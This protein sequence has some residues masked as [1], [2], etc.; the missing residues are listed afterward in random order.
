[1][2]ILPAAFFSSLRTSPSR[3]SRDLIT[4]AFLPTQSA[5]QLVRAAGFFSH[6]WPAEETWLSINTSDAL[7][8]LRNRMS[9]RTSVT[10][11]GSIKAG[12]PPKKLSCFFVLHHWTRSESPTAPKQFAYF[13]SLFFLLKKGFRTG[14]SRA[15]RQMTMIT[16]VT[17]RDRIFMVAARRVSPSAMV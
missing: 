17:G 15:T 14:H 3:R 11:T 16:P 2:Y 1:M 13:P 12:Q 9:L 10:Y 6:C 5:I 8:P 4:A 7:N